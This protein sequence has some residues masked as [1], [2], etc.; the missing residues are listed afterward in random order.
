MLG[1]DYFYFRLLLSKVYQSTFSSFDLFGNFSN[2]YEFA[3]FAFDADNS[4]VPCGCP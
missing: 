1:I 4:G 2:L 3:K